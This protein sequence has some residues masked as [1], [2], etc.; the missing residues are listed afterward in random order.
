[1]DLEGWMVPATSDIL[2]IHFTGGAMHMEQ[3]EANSPWKAFVVRQQDLILGAGT[4]TSSEV[5]WKSLSSTPTQTLHLHLSKDLLAR[6][7][8]EVGGYD[9]AHLSLRSLVGF[10]DPL[11]L[12]ESEMSD[13]GGNV[14]GHQLEAQ[15]A[16]DVSG[17]PV[18]L[19]FDAD[20]APRCG[21]LRHKLPHRLDGHEAAGKQHQRLPAPVYLVVEV[22]TVDRGVSAFLVLVCGH[23]NRS[24]SSELI[25]C[26]A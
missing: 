5:R 16:L 12:F 6:A 19:Q 3:R 24:L 21:K 17:V 22:Q 4:D 13:Q 2:L 15:W 8:E 23:E 1:M 11:L 7:A 10:Q 25:A 9:P 14:I 18:P 26:S 20:D